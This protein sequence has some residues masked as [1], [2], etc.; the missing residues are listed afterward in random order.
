MC[1]LINTPCI[2][3]QDAL[4]CIVLRMVK[5]L[6]LDPNLPLFLPLCYICAVLS[7]S[8]HGILDMGVFFPETFKK[9]KIKNKHA[10][11]VSAETNVLM[12][13]P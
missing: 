13:L 12:K 1:K 7:L 9:I 10:C 2:Y 5:R 3:H 8:A 4:F 11:I 6:P